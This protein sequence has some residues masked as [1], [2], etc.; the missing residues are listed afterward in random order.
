MVDDEAEL[1]ARGAELE[2]AL[3]TTDVIRAG[4]KVGTAGTP[5][6][7]AETLRGFQALGFDYFIAM[8]P[9][10]Q[11]AEMLQRFSQ[12]VMPLLR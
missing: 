3:G 6:Q 2:K 9:Y 4:R 7:V 12:Q 10:K 11:D 8:F 5:E 1:R